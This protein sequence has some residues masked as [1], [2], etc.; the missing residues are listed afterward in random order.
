MARH[1]ILIPAAGAARRMRGG[2]KLLEPVGG[3][4]LLRRQVLAAAAT[5]AAVLVTVPTPRHPRAQALHGTQA[6]IVPVPDA[7]EGMA[8]SIR[9]AVASLPQDARSLT[10]LPGDMPDIGTD[11]LK[12]VLAAFDAAGG[13]ALVRAT[14][15]DGTPG[16]PVTFPPDCFAAL[17][18]LFGD[19]GAGAVVRANRDRLRHVPLPGTAALTDLDTPEVW[20]A[21]RRANPDA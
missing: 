9:R 19:V 4:P 14:A 17:A 16:H 18:A 11:D 15:Q 1:V 8:A 6:T 5:G 20:A 13:A 7:A 3:M 2:D 10:V 12:A 21:W